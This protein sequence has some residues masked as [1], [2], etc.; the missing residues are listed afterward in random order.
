MLVDSQDSPPLTESV[1]M[2]RSAVLSNPHS[3]S[4]FIPFLTH[5]A[6]QQNPTVQLGYFAM[7]HLPSAA[8][9]HSPS[10]LWRLRT[11]SQRSS[12][13]RAE[14]DSSQILLRKQLGRTT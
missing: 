14:I 2:Q 9:M 11:I 13:K 1:E 10:S 7:K 3:A 8:S 5:R 12:R 4:R 6:N